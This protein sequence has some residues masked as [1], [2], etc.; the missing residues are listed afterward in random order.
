MDKRRTNTL[1]FGGI[2]LLLGWVYY[3]N[4]PTEKNGVRVERSILPMLVGAVGGALVSDVVS[5]APR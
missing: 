4:Q 1:L 2:G 5:G 3:E